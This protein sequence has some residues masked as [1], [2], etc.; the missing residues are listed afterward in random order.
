[1]CHIC[2]GLVDRIGLQPSGVYLCSCVSARKRYES[3]IATQK[4]RIDELET[5][6]SRI[7]TEI[8]NDTSAYRRITE[9]ECDNIVKK[10]QIEKCE[11]ML[12]A[13]YRKSGSPKDYR[14]WRNL[15]EA[16]I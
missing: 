2:N 9:L 1:M 16:K 3:T 11:A 14:D 6:L 12:W 7:R 13:A 5:E 8:T 4:A 15:I 10:R